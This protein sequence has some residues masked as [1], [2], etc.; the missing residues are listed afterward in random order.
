M[1]SE[2]HALNLMTLY[3]SNRL[4]YV[5]FK[6]FNSNCKRAKSGVPQ[7]FVLE[8]LLIFINANDIQ[9]CTSNVPSLFAGDTVIVVCADLLQNL[10]ILLNSELQKLMLGW[11]KKITINPSKFYSLVIPSTLVVNTS[12]NNI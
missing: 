1:E 5:S 7:G 10:V 12:S 8:P 3:L 11:I 6:C 2:D 4:Q 9:N